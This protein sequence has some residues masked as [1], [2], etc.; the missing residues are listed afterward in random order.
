MAHA[1]ATHTGVVV[2][3]PIIYALAFVLVLVLEWM[4]PVAIVDHAATS[5]IGAFLLALGVAIDGWGAYTLYRGNTSIHPGHPAS[6]LVTSGPFRFSRNPLYIGL[7]LAFIG[8]VLIVNSLWGLLLLVPVV[9]A[10]HYGVVRREEQHLEAGFG[11]EFRQY[12]SRV[13]RYL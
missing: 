1:D 6:R 7:N 10:M 2:P 13:R 9:V 12:R 11:E 5:W 4:R 3:P 8:L